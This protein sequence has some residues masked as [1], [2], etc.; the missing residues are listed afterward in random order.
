VSF[1][2]FQKDGAPIYA[3]TKG[4]PIEQMAMDQLYRTSEMGFIYHHVAVM[5]DV[6][7]G[8]G[9]TVGSVIA[10]KGAIIPAAVGVDIGCG[11]VAA[12]T[13]LRAE[14]LPDNLSGVRAEIERMIPHGRTKGQDKGAFT[15]PPR[16]VTKAWS[17]QLSDGYQS[18]CDR[19]PGALHQ[20]A[21][22][23]LG[24]LGTGNHFVEI[25]LDESDAVWIM[26]HSG[27]RGPGNRIGTYFIE[28]AKEEMH[29]NNL[30]LGDPD[31]AYLVECTPTFA[32]YW[33]GLFWAQKYAEVNR[34]LMLSHATLALSNAVQ[35]P[36]ILQ[37]EAVNCHHN[38]ASI[39]V[40]YGET[41]MVTRKGAVRAGVGELGIIPGSMGAKSYIVSGK[42]NPESFESCSH[43]AGRVLSRGAA[44]REITLEEFQ[45]SVAHVECR[46]TADLIDEAP[47][48]YKDIEAVMKAQE[49]LVEI[50]HTLRAVCCVKG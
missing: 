17:V 19:H 16:W 38:Y 50:V 11:M 18:L 42:G 8:K 39:E 37:E 35:I 27:S 36:I 5:P 14:N 10:T 32:D 7:Y 1:E 22:S 49:D 46:K 25:C 3:W 15:D 29:A 43:G 9:A 23:H 48:A 34:Q 2:R 31:L 41:V 20:R 30:T 6:H 21:L 47:A 24:T 40:H 44:K 13:N 12:R 28:L 4:V 33:D 26:L 45:A